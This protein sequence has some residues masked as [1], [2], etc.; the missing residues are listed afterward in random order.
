VRKCNDR[1][2]WS[3]VTP[4]WMSNHN[5]SWL[6]GHIESNDG[7]DHRPPGSRDLNGSPA[8]GYGALKG[9]K[10]G[11]A[12]LGMPRDERMMQSTCIRWPLRSVHG[13]SCHVTWPVGICGAYPYPCQRC[14]RA[15]AWPVARVHWMQC[16]ACEA[17]IW[18]LLCSTL[19]SIILVYSLHDGKK[20]SHFCHNSR[21]L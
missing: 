10:K 19:P 15:G 11:S 13:A 18:Q 3:P 14:S 6:T 16:T 2:C 21:Q 5:F 20:L 17:I 12:W 9:K 1:F 4:L 8:H 7:I